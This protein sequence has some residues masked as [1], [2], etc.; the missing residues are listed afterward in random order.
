MIISV[1]MTKSLVENKSRLNDSQNDYDTVVCHEDGAGRRPAA[2]QLHCS[3]AAVIN[4]LDAAFTC[5]QRLTK[6]PG[7]VQPEL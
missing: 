7:A 5:R 4:Y 3:G 6:T 2:S 1:Q